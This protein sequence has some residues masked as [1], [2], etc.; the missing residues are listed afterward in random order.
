M[1]APLVSLFVQCFNHAPFLRDCIESVLR[2][3]GEYLREI[4]VLDDAS[5]D[6]TPAIVRSYRDPRL[7]YVRHTTNQGGIATAEEGYRLCRGEFIARI[8]GDDRYR[9]DFLV[10]TIPV[11]QSDS[12]IGLVYGDIAMIDEQGG[13]LTEKGMVQR[14]GRPARGDEY[15]ALL[16]ENFVP[17]PATM[18]RR[19]AWLSALPLPLELNF[20]DWYV[21]LEIAMRWEFCFVDDVLAEY[22]LHNS[23]FHRLMTRDKRGE[24]TA[25]RVLNKHFSNGLREDEKRQVKGKVYGAHYLNHADKYFGNTMNA[26]ARRCYLQALRHRPRWV[27]RPGILRRLAATFVARRHYESAKRWVKASLRL[28]SARGG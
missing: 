13:V 4:L 16:E 8:D 3:R 19:E 25:L 14:R 10:R 15:L 27:F 11:L 1:S 28:P 6:E 21:T 7:R 26:E 9:P 20:C 24:E 23:N 12:R 22:R 2:L 18:A 17:A 5:D